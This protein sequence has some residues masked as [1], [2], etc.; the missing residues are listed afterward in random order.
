MSNLYQALKKVLFNLVDTSGKH[1]HMLGVEIIAAGPIVKTPMTMPFRVVLCI[2]DGSKFVVWNEIFRDVEDT[3]KNF[4]DQGSYFPL[5]AFPEAYE[6]F[7]KRIAKNVEPSSTLYR[8]PLYT[9]ALNGVNV[10]SN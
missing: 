4:M 6:S 10:N 9:E 5:T 1:R 8:D 7:A 2:Q 3:S